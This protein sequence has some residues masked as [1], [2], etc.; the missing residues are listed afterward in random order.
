MA[1]AVAASTLGL[2]MAGLIALAWYGLSDLIARL[3]PGE[4]SAV[5]NPPRALE[6]ASRGLYG[7]AAWSAYLFPSS[8]S[9]GCLI[10]PRSAVTALAIGVGLAALAYRRALSLARHG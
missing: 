8:G 5:S 7:A 4:H 1:P 6:M 3:A 10:G 2:A 9:L